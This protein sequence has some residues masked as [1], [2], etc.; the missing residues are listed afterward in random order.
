MSDYHEEEVRKHLYHTTANLE[1]I[2]DRLEHLADSNLGTWKETERIGVC[3]HALPRRWNTSPGSSPR[4]TTAFL[5]PATRRC[6]GRGDGQ[7]ML[8]APIPMHAAHRRH[9]D[10]RAAI[11]PT[12]QGA[13]LQK[14]S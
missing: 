14:R 10:P 4:G 11:P 6:I 9:H 13:R 8:R 3:W 2:A 5:I 1:V 12:G 7:G